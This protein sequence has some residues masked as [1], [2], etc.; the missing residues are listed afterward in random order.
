MSTY[1]LYGYGCFTVSIFHISTDEKI[2]HARKKRVFSRWILLLNTNVTK[3]IYWTTINHASFLRKLVIKLHSHLQFGKLS[4]ATFWG[5]FA[6]MLSKFCLE[7]VWITLFAT[8][9]DPSL[10]IESFA[11]INLRSSLGPR[12]TLCETIWYASIESRLAA[13]TRSRN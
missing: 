12:F 4:F 3:T 6:N 13:F 7:K 8:L 11:K 1:L 5:R 2:C 10:R 9:E